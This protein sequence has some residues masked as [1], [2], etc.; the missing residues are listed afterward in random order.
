MHSDLNEQKTAQGAAYPLVFTFRDLL[1]GRGFIVAV[2]TV[3]RAILAQEPEG[4]T[5]YGV[6]PGGVAG[7]AE[8]R[9]AALA[10]FR[11]G[12]TQV[13]D[14]IAHEAPDFAAFKAAA[15]AV[16]RQTNEDAA[17]EWEALRGRVR[18]GEIAPDMQR[19]EGEVRTCVEVHLVEPTATARAKSPTPALNPESIYTEAA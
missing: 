5:L 18:A 13:L 6:N 2:E 16:V 3:G 10:D 1:A 14:D 7:G 11:R 8:D 4:W 15:E 9:A 19:H 12:Y 17:A